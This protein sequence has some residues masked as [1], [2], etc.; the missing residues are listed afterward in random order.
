MQSHAKNFVQNRLASKMILNDGKRTPMKKH[1]IFIAQYATAT[2]CRECL[3]KWYNI[4]KNKEL[5]KVEQDYIV[6][7]IMKWIEKEYHMFK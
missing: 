1:P 7:V 3:Y 5:T 2:C 4:S 6:R